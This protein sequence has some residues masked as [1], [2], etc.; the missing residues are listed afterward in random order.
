MN[1]RDGG[2]ICIGKGN[3]EWNRSGPHGVGRIMSRGDAKRTLSLSDY[4]AAMEG[5]YTTCVSPETLDEAPDAYKPMDSILAAI[6]PTAEV[7]DRL[8]PVYNFKAGG[9]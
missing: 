1:M 7:A 8:R 6:G 9:K 3:P 5:I 4:T 2:L